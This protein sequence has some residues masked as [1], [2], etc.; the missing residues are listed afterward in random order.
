MHGLGIYDRTSLAKIV[1]V[2][3]PAARAAEWRALGGLSYVGDVEVPAFEFKEPGPG[4]WISG[5]EL[6]AAAGQILQVIDGRFEARSERGAAGPWLVLRAVDSS[7]WE[8]YSDDSKVEES[9]RRAFH[10]I[11]PAKYD[12]DTI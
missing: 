6:I 7:W 1:T 9:L 11:R 8:V 4:P 3:G 12:E 5:P 10:D 2:L